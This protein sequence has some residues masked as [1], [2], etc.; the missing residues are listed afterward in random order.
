MHR[1]VIKRHPAPIWALTLGIFKYLT[2]DDS[3]VHVCGQLS[4][5]MSR[6]IFQPRFACPIMYLNVYHTEDLAGLKI[7]PQCH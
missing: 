1:D 7:P 6:K 5:R 4:L 2:R 3:G